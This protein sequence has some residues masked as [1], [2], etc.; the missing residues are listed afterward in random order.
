VSKPMAEPCPG[1]PHLLSDLV[2]EASADF[3]PRLSLGWAGMKQYSFFFVCWEG[4]VLLPNAQFDHVFNQLN[5]VLCHWFSGLL[6][7]CAMMRFMHLG[8][9]RMES[10]ISVILLLLFS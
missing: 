2:E 5:F 6:F 7:R 1:C 8:L 10:V 4:F 3:L 9:V